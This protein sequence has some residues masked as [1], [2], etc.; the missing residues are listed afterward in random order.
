[1]NEMS[2]DDLIKITEIPLLVKFS[3]VWCAPC[4]AVQP[5]LEDLATEWEGDIDFWEVD[6]DEDPETATAWR[7]RS[8][9]TIILIDTD[10][11]EL[12]RVTG[13]QDRGSLLEMLYRH[14]EDG[15]EED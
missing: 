12:E 1:M 10:G 7:V 2:L 9:P 5:V 4:K 14:F 6:C 8:I 15:T 3:A 13:A 11:T